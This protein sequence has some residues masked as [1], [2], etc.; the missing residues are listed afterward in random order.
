MSINSSLIDPGQSRFALI[1]RFD[2][3]QG[4]Q[5]D[6]GILSYA[7]INT[8][9]NTMVLTGLFISK[10]GAEIDERDTKNKAR[11][12]IAHSVYRANCHV[13]SRFCREEIRTT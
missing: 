12:D 7:L 6:G 11:C 8:P 5:V 13:G 3:S 2:K 10:S 9:V 1:Y 4:K